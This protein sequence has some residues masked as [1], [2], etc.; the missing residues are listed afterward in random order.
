M[1]SL[2]PKG[3]KRFSGH[4]GSWT[5]DR[6]AQQVG[7]KPVKQGCAWLLSGPRM[8]Q[9][10][11]LVIWGL[12]PEEEPPSAYKHVLSPP[13]GN[14]GF[15]LSLSHLVMCL[16]RLLKAAAMSMTLDSRNAKY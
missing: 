7:G 12:G 9:A 6:L 16:K 2:S 15:P 4:L 5:G 14:S 10:A 13:A 8:D 1:A 3:E 11:P